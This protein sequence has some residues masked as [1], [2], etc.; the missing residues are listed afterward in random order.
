MADLMEF[1]AA[2]PDGL[3][4]SI[5]ELAKA[6]G[7]DKSQIS[8]KV[9]EIERE[10][11]IITRPGAGREKLVNVAEYDVA[12]G[13]VTDFSH[14]LG[15]ETARG[16]RDGDWGGD[17]RMRDAKTQSAQLEA[18]LKSIELRKQTG[19]LVEIT[20]VNEVIAEVGEAIKKPIGQV[21]LRAD[22]ITAA[23]Q[24]GGAQAVR[25]LLGQIIF[26]V[27]AKITDALRKLD[28]RSQA[29]SVGG[30]VDNGG[31]P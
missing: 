8:R 28:I 27:R 23:A 7:V 2:E 15:A 13:T 24:S 5:T 20:R 14:Q 9:A 25:T 10:G 17:T 18:A 6:K 11:R 4:L 21:A 1:D 16:I 26:D 3:W 19:A 12:L 30:G 22:D 31:A 29:S